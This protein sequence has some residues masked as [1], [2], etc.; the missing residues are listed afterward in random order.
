ML[1]DTKVRV[2]F[3]PSPTGMMH[4]GNVRSALMNFLYARQHQGTF[5]IRVE[6]T[7]ASRNV[8]PEA[9]KIIS[10]LLWLGLEYQEG[11]L[12]G[13]PYAPYY[14]SQRDD[15]Y[16]KYLDE[17]IAKKHVYRCFCTPEE[18]EKKRQRQLA[19][20]QPPRYD[21]TCYKL[22][23]AQIEEKLQN[24]VEF[25]WRVALDQEKKI[26]ISDLAHGSIEFDLKNFPDFPLTRA[27]S[28]FTFIFANFV[29]D[30]VMKISQVIR[31]EDHLT[32]TASQAVLY[33]IFQTP[34]PI[35][36]HLPIMCNAE[37]KKLSKRDFGFSLNDL[38][39]EGFVP[40]AITN[41]LATIGGGSFEQEIMS[42]EELAANMKF[43]SVHSTGHIRYDLEKLTWMNHKWINKY[44]AQKL[45]T[46][47][48]PFLLEAYPQAAQL[49]TATLSHMLQLVK[50]DLTTLKSC[51]KSL[52]F[53]FEKP[54]IT[55]ENFSVIPADSLQKI[56]QLIH[57]N[58]ELITNAVDFANTIKAEA[59]AQNIPL[60]EL[61]W[62]VRIALMGEQNGPAIHDLINILGSQESAKRLQAIG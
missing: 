11:P 47:C 40:E 1:P 22:T 45:T 26:T 18:L 37:G 50:T 54:A 33:D 12:K 51:V 5:I 32:N 3:A 29:D 14:Q 21:R 56:K 20:K 49:D 13:G 48:L 27:D 6:D 16:K 15:I 7:D 19:L 53:Y 52:K 28:S 43:D 42:L 61:F 62:Y 38:I 36:W 35:F 31:G 60:K 25:V 39:N 4:L 8:D 46:A 41:Y 34:L 57:N 44:D 10:D 55:A 24:K 59:K 2:R 9:K 58:L 17:L 23:P 30:M